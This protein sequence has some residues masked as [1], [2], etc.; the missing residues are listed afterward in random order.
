LDKYLHYPYFTATY[1]AN[2]HYHLLEI[3]LHYPL[4][5][6]HEPCT[7][8]TVCMEVDEPASKDKGKSKVDEIKKPTSDGVSESSAELAKVTFVLKLMSDIL[9]MY[10]HAVGVVL[11]CDSESS[12]GC[13]PCHLG[14]D[15]IGHSGI[16]YHVLHRLLPCNFDTLKEND[17]QW[18][19]KLSEKASW[20]LVVLCCRSSEGRK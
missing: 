8:P 6:K 2:L 7:G 9:L 4:E 12:Q 5:S 19:E 14:T 1:L 18:R 13:G 20:F 15:L 11:Q 17:Y 10:I 3:I 16:L